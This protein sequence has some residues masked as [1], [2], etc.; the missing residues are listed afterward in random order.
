MDH[1]SRVEPK[2]SVLNREGEELQKY[3]YIS[4]DWQACARWQVKTL[5]RYGFTRM[6]GLIKVWWAGGV[7]RERESSASR[8]YQ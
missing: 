1:L 3:D 6:R 5:D 8:K 2:Y 7:E 4:G